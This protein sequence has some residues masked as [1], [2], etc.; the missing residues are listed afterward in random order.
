[1]MKKR[2]S[3]TLLQRDMNIA[4]STTMELNLSTK[5]I[6]SKKLYCRKKYRIDY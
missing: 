5:T 1:M 4:K 3:K 6:K 2:K